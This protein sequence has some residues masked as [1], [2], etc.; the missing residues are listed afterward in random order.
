MRVDPYAA[1]GVAAFLAV[2][3]MPVRM[4]A[5]RLAPALDVGASTVRYA[6]TTSISATSVSPTLRVESA[7]ATFT[8][9]G[10]F[11]SISAGGWTSQGNLIASSFV[12]LAPRVHGELAASAGGSAHEDQTTTGQLLAQAR[13]HFMGN[14]RGFWLGGGFGRSWDGVA[15]HRLTQLDLGTWLSNGNATIVAALTPTA[16]GDEPTARLRYADATLGARVVHSRAELTASLGAR[17]GSELPGTSGGSAWGSV[18]GAVWLVGPVALTASAGTYPIDYT[19]GYPGGRFAAVALRLS[20]PPVTKQMLG[21]DDVALAAGR[22]S[23]LPA[24]PIESFSIGIAADRRHRTIA[25]RARAVSAVEVTGDFTGWRPAQLTRGRDGRW[26]ATLP[27]A[28]GTHE[29]ALRL[30]GGKWI[31]P[32]GLTIIRDEFGGMSGLLVVK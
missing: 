5:Q 3:I 11:S 28:P 4:A 26:A 7:S 22:G 18:G 23:D 12:A 8:A 25:V 20:R 29:I 16:L 1:V 9:S 10:T 13:A 14:A 30:D 19:Q 27:I 15:A 21:S 17:F 24:G 6:D 2:T 31:V 32:P